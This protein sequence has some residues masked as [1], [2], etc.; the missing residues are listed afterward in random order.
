MTCI[1]RRRNEDGGIA[2][3]DLQPGTNRKWIVST[4][5]R[6]LYAPKDPVPVLQEAGRDSGMVRKMSSPSGFVPG[7]SSL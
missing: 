7:P 4:K 3:T 2:P 1:L 6:P 5:L